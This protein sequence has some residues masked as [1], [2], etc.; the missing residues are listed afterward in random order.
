MLAKADNSAC[1]EAEAE[2][3]TI[4]TRYNIQDAMLGVDSKEE[5]EEIRCWGQPFDASG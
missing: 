3:Q 5:V 2:A 4:M 1:T